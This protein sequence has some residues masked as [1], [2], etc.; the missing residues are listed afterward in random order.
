MDQRIWA[1]LTATAVAIS[2]AAPAVQ[3]SDAATTVS[4]T[5][6]TEL[7]VFV[8]PKAEQDSAAQ[9]KDTVECYDSAKQRTGIDLPFEISGKFPESRE[10]YDQQYG[11]RGWTE[12]VVW[13]LAIGQGENQQSLLGMA[14]F[15]GALATGETP[16]RPHLARDE[17]RAQRRVEWDL[18]L[19]DARRMELVDAMV[20]VANEPGGTAYG[21]RLR[22]WT[23]AGKTG[24]SQNPFG[25][26]HSWFIGFAPAYDPKIIVAAI[27]EQGHPDGTVSLAVPLA[28]RIVARYLES[29]GAPSEETPGQRPIRVAAASTI[30]SR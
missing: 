30:V 11:P 14:Q 7:G 10:W 13:N 15:Y 1:M 24:T 6:Q 2:A 29:I 28:T 12:S 19:P 25:A 16:I 23:L 4:N 9:A 22:D 3:A 17:V 18:K 8:Y 27:V 5:I 26:P 21:N 20:R